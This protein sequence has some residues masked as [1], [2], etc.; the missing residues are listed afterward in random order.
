[1]VFKDYIKQLPN[2]QFDTIKKIA[3]ITDSSVVSVYRWMNGTARPHPLKQ[4]VI[5][6]YLKIN[7]DELFPKEK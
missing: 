3:E 7:V 2:Q 6:E 4:R 5:A 1:M